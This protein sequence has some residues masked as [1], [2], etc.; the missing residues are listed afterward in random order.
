MK[1]RAKRTG[2]RVSDVTEGSGNV[3][4]DLGI[5]NPE[6]E[7]FKAKLTLQIYTILKDSRMTQVQIAKDLGLRR[8]K[9]HC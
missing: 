3:F 9:F 4:A 7:L 2:K 6:Q 5:S 8:R 1:V